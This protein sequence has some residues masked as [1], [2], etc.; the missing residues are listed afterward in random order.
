MHWLFF[1]DV[2]LLLY[3]FEIP[4][5]L[6]YIYIYIC[7]LTICNICFYLSLF[8]VLQFFQKHMRKHTV[9]FD[10]DKVCCR[11]CAVEHVTNI[12]RT[13]RI[14]TLKFEEPFINKT[15]NIGKSKEGW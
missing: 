13:T 1:T 10:E 15:I 4:L 9:E 5:L 14:N 6:V 8:C 7:F 11:T 3:R 12:I 2:N